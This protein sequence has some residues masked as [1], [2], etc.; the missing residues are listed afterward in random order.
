M[1]SKAEA[2]AELD[3]G[4][5]RFRAKIVDLPESA[6]HEQWLGTWTLAHLCAHMSGWWREMRS[7]LER[8]QRGE[9]PVP[10]GVDY[11]DAET[12]NARFAA[13]APPGRA[14][15]AIWEASYGWYRQ[16]A[17]DLS[18]DRY[19]AGDDGRPKIGNRLLHGAGI[20]HF[21]EHEPQLDAWLAS[22]S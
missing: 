19:G 17:M 6:W 22:R 20:H 10:E 12:W 4:Y 3:A 15:L 7:S 1:A 9:R 8:V 14:A 5:Q 2:L 21:E 18:D 16:A 13:T 11:S